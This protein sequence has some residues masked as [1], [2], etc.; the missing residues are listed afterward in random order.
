MS[1]Q[2]I[3]QKAEAENINTVSFGTCVLRTTLNTGFDGSTPEELKRDVTITVEL[4]DDTDVVKHMLDRIASAIRITCNQKDGLLKG[5]PSVFDD[6]S[7]AK[8]L[9]SIN[10]EVHLDEQALIQ[11]YKP[12]SKKKTPGDETRA[13]ADN[14]LANGLIDEDAH[15]KAYEI[16][17]EQDEEYFSKQ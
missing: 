13:A 1:F 5:A 17:K 12:A 9:D 11:L 8:Y 3:G 14:M 16:A 10:K 4:S 6:E 15:K 2:T 7:Y